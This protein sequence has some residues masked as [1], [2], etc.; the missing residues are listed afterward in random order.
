M[1]VAYLSKIR[2]ALNADIGGIIE[3][4]GTAS[5]EERNE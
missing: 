5:A 1:A 3:Y 4:V 2:E